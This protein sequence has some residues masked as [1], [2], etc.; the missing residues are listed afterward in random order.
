MSRGKK[1]SAV[2]CLAVWLLVSAAVLGTWS[3]VGDAAASLASSVAWRG[4]F[5]DLLVA[6]ASAA[7]LACASWLWV[8]TTA[9]VAGVVAGR[10]PSVA[11]QGVTRRLVLVACGAAVVAGVGSPVLAD[12][13]AVTIS[14]SGEHS[15]VGLPMPD[16]AVVGN[17]WPAPRPAPVVVDRPAPR[18][19]PEAGAEPAAIT[20]RAGDSLWSIAAARLGPGADVSEI[21]AAWRELYAANRDAIGSDADLILPGLDLEQ[22][23]DSNR[24]APR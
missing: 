2:R 7:L 11:P 8:I 9:T 15:L 6:V 16:R 22:G 14:T 10:E 4:S 18:R 17:A 1:P 19:T 20:V 23:P 12:T 13:A 24:E 3:E 5:E 21:D